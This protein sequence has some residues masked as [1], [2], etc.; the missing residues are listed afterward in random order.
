MIIYLLFLLCVFTFDTNHF[1]VMMHDSDHD[2]FFSDNDVPSSEPSAFQEV[3]HQMLVTHAEGFT[4]AEVP[5]PGPAK[6]ASVSQPRFSLKNFV[7]ERREDVI[8]APIGF[9]WMEFQ[10]LFEIVQGSL[11]QVT[12]GRR[13]A[14]SQMELFYMMISLTSGM[15]LRKVAMFFKRSARLVQNDV[16]HCLNQLIH[17]LTGRFL[18]ATNV[19]D[20][21]P[22]AI[23]ADFPNAFGVVDSFPVF[24]SRL[25]S[26]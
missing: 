24:I 25:Q 26:K 16:V 14:L 1:H 18:P 15:T 4:S 23:F 20:I 2:E 3:L 9:S 17:P 12:P 7:T 19:G 8:A 22:D 11:Q 10:E 5:E 13:M 6:Y 21:E